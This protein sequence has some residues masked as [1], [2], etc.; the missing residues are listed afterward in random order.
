MEKVIAIIGPTAVG[1]TALS[2]S[3]ADPTGPTSFPA[4]PIR[5]IAIW[6]SVRLSRRPTNWLS[7]AIT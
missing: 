4:M 7:T 2:F 1:K 6:I 5:F 3:L